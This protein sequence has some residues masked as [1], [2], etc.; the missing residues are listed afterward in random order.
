MSYLPAGRLPEYV[1][2]GAWTTD[3]LMPSVL[4]SWEII[5]AMVM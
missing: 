5:S 3:E 4:S 2:H 1:A